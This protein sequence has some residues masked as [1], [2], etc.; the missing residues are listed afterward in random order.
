MVRRIN[1]RQVMV[2]PKTPLSD[3]KV[4]D[5]KNEK[6]FR[7]HKEQ[8]RRT[9]DLPMLRR[10][11]PIGTVLKDI[12][13]ETAESSEN[14]KSVTF[15]RQFG[16]YPLLVAVPGHSALN[17]FYDIL[18]TG[19]GFRSITGIPYPVNV[20]TAPLMILKEVPGLNKSMA[21]ELILKRP[22]KNEDDLTS[23]FKH[24]KL[25]SKYVSFD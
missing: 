3:S 11:V 1:L 18:V 12:F 2:F 13:T 4:S 6:L 21:E 25:I 7:A 22:Y 10:V 5:F 24:G 8:I 9:I 14:S 23:R 20:N 19:H 16:T 15:G 17:R